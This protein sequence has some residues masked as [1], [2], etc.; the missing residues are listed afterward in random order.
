MCSFLFPSRTFLPHIHKTGD[1]VK[2]CVGVIGHFLQ[3]REEGR[4]AKEPAEGAVAQ[5]SASLDAFGRVFP[6]AVIG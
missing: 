4:V 3:W 6:S 1:K 2:V 5:Q